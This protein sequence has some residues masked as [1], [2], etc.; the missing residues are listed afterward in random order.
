MKTLLQLFGSYFK[1]GLFSIGGGL[2]MVPLLVTEFQNRGWMNAKEFFEILAI[3]QM[4]PGAIAVNAATYVG[5][6]VAGFMGGVFATTGLAAPSVIII[7]ALSPILLKLKENSWKEAFFKGMQPVTVA[8]IL[9]AGYTII[10][11]TFWQLNNDVVE[12]WGLGLVAIFTVFLQVFQKVHPIV[13]ISI[14][15]IVGLL[16]F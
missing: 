10:A 7:L 14:G 6:D 13:V 9:Y 3:S 11:E 12:W 15:A 4:T 8:L 2:A 1:I 5:N 16:F